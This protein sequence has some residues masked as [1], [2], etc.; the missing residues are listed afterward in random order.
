MPKYLLLLV[1]PLLWGCGS[2]KK[3]IE[4]EMAQRPDW[5][6]QQP[7]D[8]EYYIGIGMSSKN[9]YNRSFVDA[10]RKQALSQIA[11]QIS[12]QISSSSLLQSIEMDQFF[13]QDFQSLIKT[14]SEQD[15]EGYEQAGV[16]ENQEQYWVYF[17]LNKNQH[18]AR[19]R[20]KMQSTLSKAKDLYRT[21]KMQQEE[22]NYTAALRN[23]FEAI[24]VVKPYWAE[25][26]ETELDGHVVFFGNHLLRELQSCLGELSIISAVQEVEVLNGDPVGV[27]DLDFRVLADG[28]YPVASMPVTFSSSL[29]YLPQAEISSDNMGWARYS[30][31]RLQTFD[32]KVNFEA[33][34][35]YARLKPANTYEPL[36]DK[37]IGGLP[38]I[39]CQKNI[40]VRQ[41]RVFIDFSDPNIEGGVQ[42]R[43]EQSVR[44]VFNR[45]D[46][47]I[48]DV[49]K[50]ADYVLKVKTD[51]QRQKEGYNKEWEMC[52]LELHYKIFQDDELKWQ[53]QS[54]AYA[55]K[56]RSYED[57]VKKVFQEA[58][59]DLQYKVAEELYRLIYGR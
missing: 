32:S 13:K 46:V 39:A 11:G 49:L 27:Q 47:L 42:G 21:A 8:P 15:L 2:S 25:S 30:I 20:Q 29:G 1:L 5:V 14:R 59:S 51:L 26:L 33:L 44:K 24:L 23:Y 58:Q 43:M 50:Q 4:R 48:T 12:T 37:I 40:L 6:Q 54:S 53:K 56:A 19:I 36:L 28:G 16:Y 38:V 45:K 9:D 18:K 3:R 10:A 34:V 35:D 52:K 41:P 22:G 55:S 17:R 7:V 57:A 31:D